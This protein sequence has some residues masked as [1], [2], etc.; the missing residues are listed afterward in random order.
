[1]EADDIT[2]M[3][4]RIA[5]GEVSKVIT[6][7]DLIAGNPSRERMMGR[8]E[9]W[10]PTGVVIDPYDLMAVIR[11]YNFSSEECEPLVNLAIT[12]VAEGIV[13]EP[14]DIRHYGLRMASY[15]SLAAKLLDD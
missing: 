13:Q 7:D 12:G 3:E 9:A 2:I 5:Q 8:L 14:G 1:M 4:K 6:Y 11:E 10:L 15:V